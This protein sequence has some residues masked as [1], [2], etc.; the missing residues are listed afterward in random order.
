VK[1]DAIILDDVSQGIA[2]YKLS[3]T[4]R[5]KTFSVPSSQCRSRHISFYDG[6]SAIITG[7]DH[8]NVYIFDRRTG[9]VQDIINIGVQD[10]VQSITVRLNCCIQVCRL[11][12]TTDSGSGRCSFDHCGPIRRKCKTDKHPSMGK[13]KHAHEEGNNK[14]SCVGGGM[15]VNLRGSVNFICAGEHASEFIISMK[16]HG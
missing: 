2:L 4:D 1:E 16:T 5:V 6:G 14:E 10:W 13:G 7:S 15:V 12:I 11:T 8:G 9:K 3:T